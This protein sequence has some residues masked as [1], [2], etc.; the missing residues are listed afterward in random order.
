MNPNDIMEIHREM[1]EALEHTVDTQEMQ[2]ARLKQRIVELEVVLNLYPMFV[3]P[4]SIVQP[5]E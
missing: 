1:D 5:I 3:E 4:L 2:N